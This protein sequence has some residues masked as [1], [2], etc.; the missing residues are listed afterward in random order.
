MATSKKP[1]MALLVGLGGDGYGEVTAIT[2]S[3]GAVLG[4]MANQ[5][6]F[7]F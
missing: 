3:E 6:K 5:F 2:L 1:L 7:I 4:G